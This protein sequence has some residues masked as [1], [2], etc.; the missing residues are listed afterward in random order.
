MEAKIHIYLTQFTR[1]ALGSLVLGAAGVFA[2]HGNAAQPSAQPTRL[3]VPQAGF[4]M[5]QIKK[6][7]GDRGFVTIKHGPI[8]SMGMPDMTMIF[9]IARPEQ[10]DGFKVGDHVLFKVEKVRSALVVVELASST[11]APAP[12]FNGPASGTP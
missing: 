2:L 10:L 8:E 3:T 11:R 7:D 5:G 1:L 6:I 12:A 4:A 9:R